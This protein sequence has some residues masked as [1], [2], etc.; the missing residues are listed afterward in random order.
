M[1]D[2]PL[3]GIVVLEFQGLAPAPFCGMILRDFGAR[4]IR[5]DRVFNGE[6]QSLDFDVLSRGK[7]TIAVDLKSKAGVEVVKRLCKNA[8][9]IIEPYRP[10]VM[11]KLGLSPKDLHEVNRKLIYAR[12]TGFGQTGDKYHKMVGHDINFLALSGMLSLFGRSNDKPLFPGNLLADMAG[13]GLM[14]ALG[15]LLSLLDKNNLDKIVDCSMMSSVSYLGT[16]PYLLKLHTDLLD[17]PRGRNFIDSGSHYYEVYQ[18]KDNKY[19]TVGAIEPHFYE[20]LLVKMGFTQDQI[21]QFPEQN[22]KSSWESMKIEF[23]KQF[24]TKTRDEWEQVFINSECCVAP[25]LEVEELKKHPHTRQL[26]M[27]SENSIKPQ[28][29]LSFYQP[30]PNNT[31]IKISGLNTVPVLKEFGF[32]PAEI[33]TLKS[34]KIIPVNLNSQL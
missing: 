32:S 5:V 9:V 4:V 3:K 31:L 20:K 6:A 30:K 27:D 29:N 24:L 21:K 26:I 14:C 12:L 19:I 34:K 28:P 33:D 13:G 22:D 15:I 11:E 17:Q 23:Q 8:N 2:G 10:G 1:S 25:L 18:T 7:E 16:F